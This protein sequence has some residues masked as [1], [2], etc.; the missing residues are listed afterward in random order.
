MTHHTSIGL[1]AVLAILLGGCASPPPTPTATPLPT[2]TATPTPTSPPTLTP[3]ATPITYPMHLEQVGQF[4]GAADALALSENIVMMKVG[5]R[6]VSIDISNPSE[7]EIIGRSI[8][9][10]DWIMSVSAFEHYAL[11]GDEKGQLW[12]FDVPAE[13]DLELVSTLDVGGIVNAVAISGQYAYLAA[14]EAGFP[15]IDLSDPGHPVVAGEVPVPGDGMRVAIQGNLLVTLG[16]AL[17]LANIDNPTQPTILSQQ[18]LGHLKGDT[19]ITVQEKRVYLSGEYWTVIDISDPSAPQTLEEGYLVIS[20]GVAVGQTLFGI[21]PQWEQYTWSQ[22]GLSAYE[23]RDLKE[24]VLASQAIAPLPEG[25]MAVSRRMI[26]RGR[27]IFF[28]NSYGLEVYDIARAPSPL[29]IPSRGEDFKMYQW[30]RV[31][32]LQTDIGT[33]SS[34]CCMGV[35]YGETHLRGDTLFSLARQRIFVWNLADPANP[36]LVRTLERPPAASYALDFNAGIVLGTYLSDGSLP[37][38]DTRIPDNPVLRTITLGSTSGYI[39]AVE[40]S[41]LIYFDN[42]TDDI[43]HLAFDIKIF[44]IADLYH[45]QL[46]STIPSI[47]GNLFRSQVDVV[48]DTAYIHLIDSEASNLAL[49]ITDPYNPRVIDAVQPSTGNITQN[50]MSYTIDKTRLVIS[51]EGKPDAPLSSL[52]LAVPEDIYED[53]G[54]LRFLKLEEGRLFIVAQW[55]TSSPPA[56]SVFIVIDVADPAHPQILAHQDIP[57]VY[58]LVK[59]QNYIFL[60]HLDDGILIYKLVPN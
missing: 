38:L 12:I 50:G 27:Y 3:T 25:Q 5:R 42:S 57:W 41:R 48:G 51:A 2:D 16:S 33:M 20:S 52:N 6:I 31:G 9:L 7:L 11:V 40:G 54:N 60:S 28:A 22:I 17:Y 29:P 37:I 59:Y 4:G 1:W 35:Y 14:S 24:P 49:D 19:E 13:G 18:T 23:M 56:R 53:S 46:M 10:P 55:T 8:L 21:D 58:H 34:G 43:A 26:A 30:Q 45:P 47:D 44:D 39:K 32:W 15:I 36:T